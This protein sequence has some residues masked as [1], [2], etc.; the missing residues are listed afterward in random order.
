M[1]FLNK[2]SPKKAYILSLDFE[3]NKKVNQSEIIFLP[4]VKLN[5]PIN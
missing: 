4:F 2:Y 1:S 3:N 5:Q